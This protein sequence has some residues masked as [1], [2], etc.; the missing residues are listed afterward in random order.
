MKFRLKLWKM[1]RHF[2]LAK[3]ETLSMEI[4]LAESK[5]YQISSRENYMWFDLTTRIQSC[6]FS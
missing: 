5:G 3:A 4:H 2:D 6:Y 1:L